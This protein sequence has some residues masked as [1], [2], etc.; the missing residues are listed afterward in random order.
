MV[1]ISNLEDIYNFLQIPP[2]LEKAK[3]HKSSISVDTI[4]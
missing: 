1:S 2:D 4:I 3:A